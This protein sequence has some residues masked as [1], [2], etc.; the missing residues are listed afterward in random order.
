MLT[1]RT[2]VC[3]FS[4]PHF[5]RGRRDQLRLIKRKEK[6]ASGPPVVNASVSTRRSAEKKEFHNG[7]VYDIQLDWNDVSKLLADDDAT[8]FAP[9]DVDPI[10]EHVHFDFDPSPD[11]R[12]EDV[13]LNESSAIDSLFTD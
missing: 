13:V 12:E 1:R 10:Q 7:P 6:M 2:P 11:C 9:I 4:H 5:V 8:L 3:T